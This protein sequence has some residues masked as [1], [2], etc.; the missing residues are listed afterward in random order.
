MDPFSGPV[1]DTIGAMAPGRDDEGTTIRLSL[2]ERASGHQLAL[3]VLRG[4]EAT[5]HALPDAGAVVIGRGA[6]ADITI[7]KSSLSRAH[8]RITTG[9][10]TRIEDLGSAN[11]TRIGGVPLAPGAP[12][13]VGI[14]EPIELGD[15]IVVLQPAPGHAAAARVEEKT[16]RAA[17]VVVASEAMKA[18]YRLADRVAAGTLSVLVT[19]ETGAGKEVVARYVHDASPRRAATFLVVNCAALPEQLLESELFGHEKGAFTGSASAKPGLLEVADGGT[20]F[21]DEIGEMAL[22]L[23]A[24]ILRV[25]EDKQVQRLGGTRPKAIDVRF[26]SATNRD[27]EAAAAEGRFR[28]DLYYRLNG[29]TLRVPPL[30]E[31]PDEVLPLAQR[32]IERACAELGQAAIPALSEGARELLV[33]H[34]WPGNVRELK[35]AIDRAVLVCERGMVLPEHL[36]EALRRGPTA[37]RASVP[38]TPAD[39]D[40]GEL[41]R[42]RIV[43]ALEACAG[44]Q[45]RAAEMLGVTRRV[46]LRR[47]DHFGIAR[48]R[49]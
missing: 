34:A 33:R 43:Q 8:A 6:D 2:D 11:G 47:L 35:S 18:L 46:L 10:T 25:L 36:P 45:T 40:G 44:N 49:R 22:P 30:R 31:R 32:M 29:V 13:V 14:G 20:V 12:V 5:S 23:Q 48:P 15:V 39:E 4:S 38:P 27:L 19:G 9:S 21:F 16:P 42:E 3:V 26:V 37:P 24:K 41:T 1:R 7:A 17:G 28:S